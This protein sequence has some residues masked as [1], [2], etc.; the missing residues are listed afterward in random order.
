[1][2][3]VFALAEQRAVPVVRKSK[4]SGLRLGVSVMV[5]VSI[6]GT[7]YRAYDAMDVN[8]TST[9][10]RGFERERNVER[11]RRNEWAGCAA[12][13]FVRMVEAFAGRVPSSVG[14]ISALVVVLA[15]FRACLRRCGGNSEAN[16][17]AS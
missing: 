10:S 15:C 5:G 16:W 12:A 13:T 1:M 9:V 17:G 3:R 8:T 6:S 11:V 4:V 2:L 14:A 7:G